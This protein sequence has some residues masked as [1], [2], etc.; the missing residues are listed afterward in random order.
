MGT[1]RRLCARLSF[2]LLEGEWS[3]GALTR[4]PPGNRQALPTY[5]PWHHRPKFKFVGTGRVWISTRGSSSLHT[6][7][8]F[9]EKRT[10]RHRQYGR[11]RAPNAVTYS[12]N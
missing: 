9:L 6:Q 2:H 3:G 7:Q 4:L 5:A 11:T 12:Q 1:P 8:A 10:A